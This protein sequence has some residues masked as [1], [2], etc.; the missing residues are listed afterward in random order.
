[1]HTDAQFNALLNARDM[2]FFRAELHQASPEGTTLREQRQIINDMITTTRALYNAYRAD[3]AEWPECERVEFFEDLRKN[4][5]ASFD[6][7][8]DILL[9]G[10]DPIFDHI[11]L[12]PA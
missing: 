12:L 11:S 1:M 9:G 2:A 5:P 7:W 4:D 10:G 8:F 3:F 6:W